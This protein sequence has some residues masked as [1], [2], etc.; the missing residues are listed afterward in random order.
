MEMQDINKI[1]DLWEI[2]G[3]IDNIKTLENFQ[4]DINKHAQMIK[5]C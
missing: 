4:I 1:K 2:C 3:Q 5:P